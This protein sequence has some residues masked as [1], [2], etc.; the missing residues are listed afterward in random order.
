MVSGS[1]GE[2]ESSGGVVDCLSV[3]MGVLSLEN[4]SPSLKTQ[5]NEVWASKSRAWKTEVSRKN[6]IWWT[7]KEKKIQ[8]SQVWALKM[9]KIWLFTDFTKGR[10]GYFLGRKLFKSQA[11]QRLVAK[12]V[13]TRKQLF[14]NFFAAR[15][16]MRTY[17]ASVTAK[18]VGVFRHFCVLYERTQTCHFFYR[19]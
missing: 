14:S 9:K 5:K 16:G 10:V 12:W 15:V 7:W 11:S 6:Q 18:T 17:F 4:S 8:T 19:T 1:D 3:T 13:G 2:Y